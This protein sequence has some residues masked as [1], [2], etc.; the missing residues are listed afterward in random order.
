MSRVL[1]WVYTEGEWRRRGLDDLPDWVPPPPAVVHNPELPFELEPLRAELATSTRVVLPHYFVTF[2]LGGDSAANTASWYLNRM[3]GGEVRESDGDWLLRDRPFD[4]WEDDR[5]RADV[6]GVSWQVLDREWEVQQALAAGF[7]GMFPD[8]LNL[9]DGVGDNRTGQVKQLLNAVTHLGVQA[10]FKVALMIDGNTS[11]SQTA[12]LA[13]LVAKT[14]ELSI[15]PAVWRLP[16]GRMLVAIYMPEGAAVSTHLGTPAEVLAHWTSYRDQ[17][18]AAG[19]QV[20]LWFCH[21]RGPW[22]GAATGQGLGAVLDPIAYGHG[23]WGSR[24]PDETLNPTIQNAGAPG[25]C[26]ATFGKPWLAPVSAQDSRPN[27]DKF[28]EARG[29]EQLIASWRVAIENG[30]DWVQ[31]PTWSDFAEH[32]HIMPSANGAWAWTDLCCYYSAR[33]KLGYWPDIK[34][35]ALYLA[36]RIH[37]LAGYVEQIPV[38]DQVRSGSTPEV[39]IVQAIVFLK[40]TAS[41]TVRV[42]SGGVTTEFT[43]GSGNAALGGTGVHLFTVPLLPGTVSAEVV[44]TGVTVARADSPHQVTL[45]PVVQDMHYRA[46]SSLRQQIGSPA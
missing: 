26:H 31:I 13:G 27:Q 2:A 29:F 39:D 25:Y 42:T 20:A 14:V 44:R 28:E 23:R 21:Q 15:H 18:A 1:P 41:T 36:H 9:N 46:V 11:I 35:D 33:F 6:D 43:P 3:P 22:Y 10:R 8:W 7:D 12:N 24:N 45:T 17:C 34:R 40:S 30:A 4:P 32:A 16:D 19:V 5:P 37:P 38:P